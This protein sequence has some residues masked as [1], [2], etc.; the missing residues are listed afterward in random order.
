MMVICCYN[1][2]DDLSNV[3]TVE[4]AVDKIGFGMFQALLSLFSGAIMVG[5]S[6]IVLKFVYVLSIHYCSQTALQACIKLYSCVSYS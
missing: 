3:Y 2:E 5:S 4:E 1:L 6:L